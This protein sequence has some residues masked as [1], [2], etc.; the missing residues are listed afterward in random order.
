MSEHRVS[1][2]DNCGKMKEMGALVL[3]SFIK[4]VHPFL[5]FL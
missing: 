1:L 4:L 5:S 2:F 3:I